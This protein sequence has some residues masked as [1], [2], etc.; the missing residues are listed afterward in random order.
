MRRY[1]PHILGYY[2]L[3]PALVLAILPVIASFEH[4]SVADYVAM[5][6]IGIFVVGLNDF[7]NW[8]DRPTP[9]DQNSN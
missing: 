6:L 1:L 2:V 5:Y 9:P 8:L 7:R 4:T 3:I